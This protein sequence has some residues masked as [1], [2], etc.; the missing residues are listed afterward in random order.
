MF[1]DIYVPDSAG[2]SDGVVEV[3]IVIVVLEGIDVI[4]GGGSTEG[5]SVNMWY[6]TIT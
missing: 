4:I 2:V 1:T 3:D 5:I 6:Q